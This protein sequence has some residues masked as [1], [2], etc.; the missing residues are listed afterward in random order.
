MSE[1][2]SGELDFAHVTAALERLDRALKSG[3]GA[4]TVDLAGVTRGD[5][6]GLALLLEVTRRARAR[7]RALSFTGTP[8]QLRKLAEFFG[9]APL[10]PLA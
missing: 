4:L 6:A 3:D 9:I 1:A 5:S 8:A 2:L 10:L 7:G